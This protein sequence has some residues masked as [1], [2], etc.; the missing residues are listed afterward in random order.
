MSRITVSGLINIETTL[1]IESFPLEYSPV[2]YPFFGISSGVAG[3]GYNIAKALTILGDDVAFASLIGQDI[4]AKE[5]RD[6]LSDDL[7]SDRFVLSNVKHT[8]Q[9]VILY[10][11]EGQRQIHVD[12]KDIQQQLYPPEL[13]EELMRSR[14]LLVLC[15]INFSRPFLHKALQAGKRIATDVHAISSLDDE[16]NRDFMQAADILF[17]SD[18]R[19]PVP[20]DQWARRVMD[21]YG[22]DILVIGLGANGAL[23]CVKHDQSVEHIPAAHIGTV[24]NTI[25]AGDALFAAFVHCYLQSANPYDAIRRAVVFAA[26]KVSSVLSADGLLD[27]VGLE[28]LY[29]ETSQA[30]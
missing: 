1:R 15:N 25:G 24:R 20:P 7:I 23:L 19:L 21:R 4:A 22:P 16:Y 5:A 10:D 17:M 28:R 8:A 9:S 2:L 29:Q 12:L 26:Y 13:F 18:E 6:A 3:V 11:A 27:S 14:D 30:N